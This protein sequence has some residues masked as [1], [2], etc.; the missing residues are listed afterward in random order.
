MKELYNQLS[1][2][3]FKSQYSLIKSSKSPDCTEHEDSSP[4]T[5]EQTIC[6]TLRQITQTT[7]THSV[8]W[9][10]LLLCLHLRLSLV[11]GHFPSGSN[12]KC[13]MNSFSPPSLYMSHPLTLIDIISLIIFDDQYKPCSSS[14]CNPLHS[15]VASEPLRAFTQDTILKHLCLYTSVNVRNK[16]HI[17]AKSKQKHSPAYFNRTFSLHVGTQKNI[18]EQN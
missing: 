7:P 15:H 5:Q 12:T 9:S 17:H 13:Y 11:C 4:S 6:R 10:I 3:F 14:I 1:K 8:T 18:Q 16:F 2:S